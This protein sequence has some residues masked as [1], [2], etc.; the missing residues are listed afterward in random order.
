MVRTPRWF[1]DKLL[2]KVLLPLRPPA[3]FTVRLKRAY[4]TRAFNR[5]EGKLVELGGGRYPTTPEALNVDTFDAPEVDVIHRLPEPLPFD[6]DSL[7][8][9]RSVATL[10]HFSVPDIRLIIRDCHRRLRPGGV[11]TVS[12]PVLDAIF[13]IYQE[14]GCTDEVL[15]YLHGGLRDERDVHLGVIS[16]KRWERELLDAG[17]ASVE[18]LPYS[19]GQHDGRYMRTF[20]AVKSVPEEGPDG[21]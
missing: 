7:G 5:R 13:E 8:E 15:R 17:F 11:F 14:E 12:V 6:E 21:N 16:S 18:Q 1:F 20:R 19:D 2:G 9:I 3:R 4:R 10:E